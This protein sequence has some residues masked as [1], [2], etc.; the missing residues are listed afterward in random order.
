MATA[1]SGRGGAARPTPAPIEDVAQ[2]P[3]ENHLLLIVGVMAA[4]LLQVLDITIAN[5]AIP[6]MQSTLSATPDTISWVLTSYI[7]AS[8][9]AM[10]ITGWLADRIGSRR[11]FVWS[12]AGFVVASM[13]CGMAQNLEEM[14]IFRAI[15]GVA[16][17]FIAPLSQA[18]MLDTTKPSKQSAI[19]ALWGMGVMIGPILGPVLGGWITENWSWRWVFYVN[20]PVG[21]VCL[22][23]L[24]AELP[25]RA[26]VRRRFDL[27][28]FAMIAICLSCLQLLLDRGTGLDWFASLETWVYAF[29]ILSTA[30]AAVIH[31]VTAR[32]PLF[33][34]HLFANVNFVVSLLFM[35]VIGVVMFATMALLPPML[36]GLFGYDVIDTGMV[37]M[38]RGVGVLISMQLSGL[39]MRR[40][41][42]ARWMVSLGFLIGAWSLYQMAGWSLEVDRY[43][44]V[45]SGLIQ[46][47]GIGLVFIPLNASAFA[48]LPPQLRTDGSSLL[49]LTRSVGSSI[50]ISVMMTLLSRNTQTSHSDLAGHITPSLTAMLDL[51]SLE[52]FQQYGEAGLGMLDLMV[53]RQA[54]MVA[55]IDDYWL[56]MWLSL[57]SVP[58]VLVM[59]RSRIPAAA[60]N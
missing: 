25:S 11:L 51:S 45:M 24:L 5:V 34:R 23:I 14:V 26:I 42:D 13:L 9:V 44:I 15:Q 53:T 59:R 3:V 49:N 40:G 54:A 33:D 30:W 2:L 52:R 22:A 12:V 57:A 39:L 48:T 20:V 8:A 27:F 6:H 21:A 36:Q 50:G 29:L 55:Y 32:Q 4:T 35:L 31:F 7:I 43:H 41:V 19:L 18:A 17:A 38:P 16:G 58:L 28:G 56:M 10:P 60:R 1:A 37:L 47:L 46:G